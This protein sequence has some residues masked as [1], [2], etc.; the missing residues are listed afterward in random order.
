MRSDQ[1]PPADD[2]VRL[3]KWLWAARFFKTRSLAAAAIQGGKVHVNG[4][5]VK[6]AHR[7]KAG[8]ALN[9][10]R[11]PDEYRVIV[12]GL[13]RIR[14]PATQAAL[15]YEETAQSVQRREALAVERKAQTALLP[16]PPRRP[17]KKERR[18]IIRFTRQTEPPN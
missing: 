6:P 2:T 3:D 14:G 4:A 5:R 12:K 8:E 16:H 7:V 9:I 10:R 13:A 1:R 17:S 11:G 15:L 18:Q